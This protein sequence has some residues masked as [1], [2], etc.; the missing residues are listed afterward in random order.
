[1]SEKILSVKDLTYSPEKG[2]APLYKDFS[3]SLEKG[4]FLL[5]AGSNG[6]GKSTLLK[7]LSGYLVPEKGMILLSG[8][9]YEK[10]ISNSESLG[11]VPQILPESGGFTV[12]ELIQMG[13]SGRDFSN[14]FLSR[15]DR[16][17]VEEILEVMEITH[18]AER[19]LAALST[20]EFRLAAIASILI[21]MPH[22]LLLDEP[23]ASLDFHHGKKLMLLLEKYRKEKGTTILMTAHDLMVPVPFATKVLLLKK[24][25]ILA[26]GEVEKVLTEENLQKTFCCDFDVTLSPSGYP[27]FSLKKTAPGKGES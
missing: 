12:R 19:K 7:L 13:C 2:K 26:E 10:G 25:E 9:S 4:E 17:K 22:L 20:G 11:Y 5:I 27:A 21:K 1:M 3:F 23:T 8:R 14:L 16:E 15:K 18:L 24:G 6:C